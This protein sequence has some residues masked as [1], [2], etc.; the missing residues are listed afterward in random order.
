M[1]DFKKKLLKLKFKIKEKEFKN[2]EVAEKLNIALSTFN[3]KLSGRIPFSLNEVKQ[4]REI[5][6]LKKEEVLEIFL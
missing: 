3:Q 4:L 6:D 5:L 2:F 1:E